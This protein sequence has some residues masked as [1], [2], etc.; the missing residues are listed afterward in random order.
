VAG[1]EAREKR[2]VLRARGIGGGG[3]E[4]NQRPEERALEPVRKGLGEA[5][6]SKIDTEVDV[7]IACPLG[8]RTEEMPKREWGREVSGKNNRVWGRIIMRGSPNKQERTVRQSKGHRWE[9]FRGEKGAE[10]G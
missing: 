8:R 2:A 7:K 9:L 6:V 5:G 3:T 1:R 4:K 10:G